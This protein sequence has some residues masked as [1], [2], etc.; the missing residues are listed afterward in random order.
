MT[1]SP[2]KLLRF[3]FARFII[4]AGNFPLTRVD[5]I[6][7]IPSMIPVGDFPVFLKTRI[8]GY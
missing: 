5:E 3:Y 2:D 1:K 8:P 6:K 4:K 7:N